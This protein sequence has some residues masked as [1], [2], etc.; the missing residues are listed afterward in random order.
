MDVGARIREA[1]KAKGWTQ[2]YLAAQCGW[3]SQ[4]R[5]SMYERGEREPSLSDLTR[6]SK[7][8]EKPV[9]YFIDSEYAG[10]KAVPMPP[11]LNRAL[12]TASIR[13]VMD[14]VLQ[15]EDVPPIDDIAEVTE[16]V[17][18][19]YLKEQAEA[20]TEHRDPASLLKLVSSR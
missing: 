13:D 16:K 18:A 5:I 10:P 19:E 15:M 9:G 20:R 12:L 8:L 4:S 17:Y 2:P 14:H 11:P 7:V 6:L 1:R 3:E